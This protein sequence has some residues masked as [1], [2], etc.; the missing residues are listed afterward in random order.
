MR[1]DYD[2]P[3]GPRDPGEWTVHL[4]LD[5]EEVSQVEAA[6]PEVL[7]A[8]KASIHFE[9]DDADQVVGEPVLALQIYEESAEGARR[10]AERLYR[11]IRDEAGLPVKAARILGHLSAFWRDASLD[12]SKEASALPR[13]GRYS[14]A[15]VRIQ[16]VAELAVIATLTGLIRDKRP[17]ED[18]DSPI[19]RPAPLTDRES[20]RLLEE[21]TG[22][23]IT[24]ESW[25]SDY[26]LHV[27]RRNGIVHAGLVVSL[28]ESFASR[29]AILSLRRWLLDAAKS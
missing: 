16:T 18:P 21:L 13:Q 25:W 2:P 19:R 27:K 4:A 12:L 1:E 8:E 29:E 26:R 24:E 15:V 6:A 14:L 17:G 20:R 22:Q 7:P 28:E 23:R 11:Q 9:Y 3:H 5:E 10:E